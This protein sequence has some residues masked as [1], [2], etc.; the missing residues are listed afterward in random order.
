MGD[1][2]FEDLLFLA[3]GCG[4]AVLYVTL[5]R[6]K[7]IVQLD[8]KVQCVFPGLELRLIECFFDRNQLLVEGFGG[9]RNL[10]FLLIA[11]ELF[12]GLADLDDGLING[13]QLVANLQRQRE[14][15]RRNLRAWS[16][17]ADRAER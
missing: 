17:P 11:G 6:R 15:A 14:V 7:F 16:S 8:G 13:A 5:E 1:Q 9:G 3:G 12:L 4:I 2:V 10:I